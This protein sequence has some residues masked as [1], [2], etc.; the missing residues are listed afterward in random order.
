[1][2]LDC[3]LDEFL[4]IIE[5]REH[6]R[7]C[8]LLAR[9][10]DED[11]LRSLDGRRWIEA[12]SWIPE[13]ACY[14]DEVWASRFGNRAPQLKVDFSFS[15]SRDGCS[16]AEK[17]LDQWSVIMSKHRDDLELTIRITQAGRTRL[18]DLAVAATDSA[19]EALQAG[20]TPG[21][22][23]FRP[24]DWLSYQ[25]GIKQPRL[26]E[27]VRDGK[28]RTLSAPRGYLDSEGKTVRI[29]YNAADAVKHCSPKRRQ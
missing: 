3:I 10:F 24:A 18:A 11:A 2:S 13:N 7:V 1:M 8:E 19:A 15:P 25:H 22:E 9:G 23:G 27:A 16:I 29:L 4:K 20:T 28:V 17:D 5:E 26:S 12:C 21:I 6:W 14:S